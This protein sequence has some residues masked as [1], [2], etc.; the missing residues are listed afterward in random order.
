[1]IQESTASWHRPSLPF[2][3]KHLGISGA[4]VCVG[5]LACFARVAGMAVPVVHRAL[6]VETWVIV[7]CLGT[8]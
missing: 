7:E 3:G 5:L 2:S 6:C 4:G 1:M 8:I